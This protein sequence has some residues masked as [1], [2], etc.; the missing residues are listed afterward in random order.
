MKKRKKKQPQ[1]SIKNQEDY[2]PNCVCVGYTKIAIRECE[3]YCN[4]YFQHKKTGIAGANWIDRL[5][6]SVV[7]T[8]SV[9]TFFNK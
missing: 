3:N 6:V 7:Y 1:K 5:H 2:K 8:F 9:R 4:P